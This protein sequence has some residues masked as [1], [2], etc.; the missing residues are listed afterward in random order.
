MQVFW[1]IQNLE[2]KLHIP[3]SSRLVHIPESSRLG[4]CKL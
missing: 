1:Q 4:G 3:E 2:N